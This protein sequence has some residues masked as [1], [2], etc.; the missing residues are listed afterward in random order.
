MI[1]V[2]VVL[3][4]A[5]AVTSNVRPDVRD[6]ARNTKWSGVVVGLLGSGNHTLAPQLHKAE[7]LSRLHSPRRAAATCPRHPKSDQ[8]STIGPR[9]LL[10]VMPLAIITGYYGLA[11]KSRQDGINDATGHLTAQSSRLP[12][13]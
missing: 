8:T 5:I 4:V 6:D 1:V 10:T 9:P 3:E 11:S 12:L 7:Y 13:P 2:V